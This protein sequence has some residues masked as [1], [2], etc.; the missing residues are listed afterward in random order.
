MVATRPPRRCGIA[1]FADDVARTVRELAPG[2]SVC[3]AVVDHAA[4]ART[5]G[6]DTRWIIRQG[7]PDSYGAA[8]EGINAAPIDVVS[9]QHE[10]GL[11]GAW[12]R[13]YRDHIAPFLDRLR[14]PLVSTLHT[15]LPELRPGVRESVRRICDRSELV[16]VASEAARSIL[17]GQ[18]GASPDRVRIVPHGAP[19]VN[20]AIRPDLKAR[21]GLAGR[22][23][24]TTFGFLSPAKGHEVMIRAVAGLRFFCP[25]ICYLVVGRPH[26]EAGPGGTA[27]LDGLRQLVR[28]LALDDHVRFVDRYLLD[29]QILDLLVASDVYVTPFLDLHQV[30]SGTLSWALAAGKAIVSTRYLH[31]EEALANGRGLLVPPGDERALARAVLRILDDPRLRKQLERRALEYGRTLAWPIVGRR[32][33]RAFRDAI[34]LAP[35]DLMF[36]R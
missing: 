8:A 6:G 34:E 5:V 28:R 14:K 33:L 19:W 36:S 17:I 32:V 35:D 26:P 20:S 9:L 18:F 23:V 7:D 21:L 30:S 3:W 2:T 13:E 12:E 25:E 16:L 27:Y 1:T 11:Y 24:V 10:F 15:A 31:A 22:V 29:R 4:A